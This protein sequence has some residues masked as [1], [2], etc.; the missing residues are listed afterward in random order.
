MGLG[1]IPASRNRAEE[2]GFD[3]RDIDVVE[4]N[5]AFAAQA[6]AVARDLE[7]DP[8]KVNPNGG[9][10]ALGHPIGASGAIIAIKALYELHRTGAATRW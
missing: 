8:A 7:F 6:C 10:V 9:A 4:S 3:D 2:G 1:P 5:E